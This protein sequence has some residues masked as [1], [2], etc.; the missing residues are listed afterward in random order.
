VL[1]FGRICIS[2]CSHRQSQIFFQRYFSQKHEKEQARAAKVDKR[3][4]KGHGSDTD[5]DHSSLSD[6]DSD[7]EEVTIWKVCSQKYH[8]DLGIWLMSWVKAMKASM[9]R[10]EVDDDAEEDD[11]HSEHSIRDSE[12]DEKS[13]SDTEEDQ[14]GLSDSS[15]SSTVDV[16]I[17]DVEFSSADT[18]DTD[19]LVHLDAEVPVEL[20]KRGRVGPAAQMPPVF[21]GDKKRKRKG[22]GKDDVRIRKKKGRTL[23]TFASYEDYAQMIEDEP[24]ENL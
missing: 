5:S 10:T 7:P 4:A 16:E 22:S 19:N 12:P 17:S 13:S 2:R 11:G 3:K 24:E 6:G 9:P 20:T 8:G 18:S 15:D 23:Q 21:N 14:E 1:L